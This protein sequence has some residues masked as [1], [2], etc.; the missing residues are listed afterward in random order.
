MI[1]RIT[2][3]SF[4]FQNKYFLDEDV[5]TIYV[6]DCPAIHSLTYLGSSS[7]LTTIGTVFWGGGCFSCYIPPVSTPSYPYLESF[8]NY[9]RAMF[10]SDRTDIS[11][12]RHILSLKFFTLLLLLLLLLLRERER[13]RERESFFAPA[14]AG[15]LSLV[16]WLSLISLNPQDSSQYSNRSMNF[17]I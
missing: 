9:F 2:W 7:A 11:I 4:T 16:S 13:E 15:C 12:K 6:V 14:F 10:R 3:V 8:S 1:H 5:R 17:I